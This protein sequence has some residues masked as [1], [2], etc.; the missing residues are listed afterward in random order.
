MELFLLM[1]LKHNVKSAYDVM[2][3]KYVIKGLGEN[4]VKSQFQFLEGLLKNGIKRLH[5][6]K[7]LREIFRR[8]RK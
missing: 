6:D 4:Q 1:N 5:D 3:K 8:V 7:K 2:A